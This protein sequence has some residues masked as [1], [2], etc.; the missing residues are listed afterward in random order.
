VNDLFDLKTN[1]QIQEASPG[2]T[3]AQATEVMAPSDHDVNCRSA[4]A[5]HSS[6]AV[7]EPLLSKKELD[8]VRKNVSDSICSDKGFVTQWDGAA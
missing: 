7:P 4:E 8:S 6:G 5:D 2:S 3:V 1:G